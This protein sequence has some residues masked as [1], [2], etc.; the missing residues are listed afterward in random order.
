MKKSLKGKPTGKIIDKSRNWFECTEC[1]GHW[2]P[3]LLPGGRQPKNSKYC[4]HCKSG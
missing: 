3:N 2:S 1:G 4:P